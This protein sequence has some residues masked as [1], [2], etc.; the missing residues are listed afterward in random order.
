MYNLVTGATGFIGFH[1]TLKLLKQNK[2][3]IGVD[4]INDYYDTEIKKN[5]LKKL[6]NFKKFKFFKFDISKKNNLKILK[7]FKFLMVY[8]LAAQAGVRYSFYN[9]EVYIHSNIQGFFN[10]LNFTKEKNI[11]KLIFASSSSVYG[12]KKKFPVRENQE[13]KPTSLYGITKKNNEEMAE[14]FANTYN[15]KII[16]LRF[17]TVFGEYGRPD[18]F[19]IK[20]LDSYKNKKTFYLNN[21]GKHIR[22]FS[23]IDDVVHLITKLKFL[24]KFEIFN[25]CSNRPVKLSSV[26]K[27][28]Q[29]YKIQPKIKKIKFQVGDVYKTHGSNKKILK[30]TRCKKIT[31]FDY[32]LEKLINWYKDIK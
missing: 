3:V 12:N 5:R 7:N 30:N 17:F 11:K 20:F 26:I 19:L 21:Y 8:H 27:L 2:K 14:Y 4:N 16:G 1:L 18:M 22:D 25:V 24:K 32:A 13:L 9:P 15:I 29:K 6:K 28:F 23:Y 31:K 10:I